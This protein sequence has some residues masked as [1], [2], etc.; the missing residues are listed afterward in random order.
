MTGNS[1][2]KWCCRSHISL[3]TVHFWYL[4]TFRCMNCLRYYIYW[5]YLDCST[6]TVDDAPTFFLML[7]T[8]R[9]WLN[10][11]SVP[12]EKAANPQPSSRVA[13]LAAAKTSTSFVLCSIMSSVHQRPPTP[14]LFLF[15]FCTK[16]RGYSVCIFVLVTNFISREEYF[17]AGKLL[18][19]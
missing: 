12:M 6:S 1:A 9:P 13:W 17:P 7:K 16:C 18:F 11:G 2:V 15:G 5:C 19:V 10:L 3:N 8:E 14:W 4:M